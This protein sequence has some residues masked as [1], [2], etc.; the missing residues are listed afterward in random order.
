MQTRARAAATAPAQ[1]KKIKAIPQ[2]LPSGEAYDIG[3][4]D[5]YHQAKGL[6][7]T[8]GKIPDGWNFAIT[9]STPQRIIIDFQ[10][11]HVDVSESF[12]LV[13]PKAK[14]TTPAVTPP[15]PKARKVRLHGKR[16]GEGSGTEVVLRPNIRIDPIPGKV[17]ERYL[18]EHFKTWR[19]RQADFVVKSVKFIVQVVG[20]PDRPATVRNDDANIF[21]IRG[22]AF[23][24]E[25][26]SADDKLRL[27]T[28]PFKTENGLVFKSERA[29][30]VVGLSLDYITWDTRLLRLGV[31]VSPR[32]TVKEMVTAAQ[33]R[34]EEQLEDSKFYTLF[35][36]GK[37]A[38]QPWTRAVYELRPNT[39][40]ATTV[41]AKS[42]DDD[43]TVMVPTNRTDVRQQM[44]YQALSNPP[45]SL[46]IPDCYKLVYPL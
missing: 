16:A 41:K 40:L 4:V 18:K 29:K 14:P 39:N 36:K 6:V 10:A 44:V 22:G 17:G 28:K 42:Q 46:R 20:E 11:D 7:E 25:E 21:E 34:A 5:D 12:K 15:K 13:Q 2:H 30:A 33:K 26:F 9:E 45:L 19:P 38:G 35:Q 1:P 27:L 32:A 3:E 23:E 37:I 31:E 24:T 43:M 8:S